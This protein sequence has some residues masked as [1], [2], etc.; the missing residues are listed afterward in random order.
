[1]GLFR[2][3]NKEVSNDREAYENDDSNVK[4]DMAFKGQQEVSGQATITDII[5][6]SFWSADANNTDIFVS[7]ETVAHRTYG[8]TMYIVPTGYPRAVDKN[9][10]QSAQA[11]GNTD[12]TVDIQ[13][14]KPRE[15]AKFLKAQ[16]TIVSSNSD[17]QQEKGQTFALKENQNK[18]QDIDTL[19][20]QNQFDENRLFDVNVSFVT[21]GNSMRELDLN[22]GQLEDDMADKGASV[23][24]YF[25]RVKTGYAQAIPIGYDTTQI[26][27]TF[28]NITSKGLG[29]F[30]LMSSGSGKF[31][32]GI[33]FAENLATAS[34][35]TEYLNVFGSSAHRPLNY[36]MGIIGES[37]GGK[38]FD[39]QI[40]I[41]RETAIL[42][43]RSRILDPEGEY[44]PMTKALGQLNLMVSADGGFVFNPI[45]IS[46][47]ELPLEEITEYREDGSLLTDDEIE[48]LY[49]LP[50]SNR[51]IVTKANGQ[52]FVQYVQLSEVTEKLKGF[53]NVNLTANEGEVGL[54]AQESARLDAV[55]QQIYHERGVT[56]DPDSLLTDQ[57]GVYQGMHYKRIPK[58]QPTLSDVYTKLLDNYSTRDANNEIVIDKEIRRVT[59][60]LKQNLRTGSVKIFDGQT[61]FGKI[62]ANSLNDFRLVNF[63]LKQLGDGPLK[64]VVY[65]VL[66]TYLWDE[67]MT[68][69]T[70][71]LE[72]KTI[73][74]DEILQNV[75][76]AAIM[77]FYEKIARRARKRNGSLVWMTQD[78][79]RFEGHPE[80]EALI[81]NTEHFLFLKIKPEHRL[82]MKVTFDLNDGVLQVLIS[83]P[84]PG[85]GILFVEGIP[86]WVRVNANEFEKDFAESNAENKLRARARRRLAAVEV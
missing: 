7:R 76:D 56:S 44:T 46:V 78:I 81:S 66:T 27:D 57:S 82:L 53:V 22:A 77:G 83:N 11:T 38:T 64:K 31:N 15:A 1:M 33:P 9:F 18:I 43:I 32:G 26:D 19:S 41:A 8:M 37:G 2:N 58:E 85:E 86:M 40:K 25:K 61:K 51:K 12:I 39:T 68:N 30:N 79:K 3:K 73:Y 67:W 69:P 84:Q 4:V 80:T 62:Q 50:E 75:D 5:A 60:V 24:P 49:K 36:N 16:R 52:K 55:M 13:P 59:D 17:Y 20:Q 21:Y 14:M 47:S 42:G 10:F 74:A 48:A 6:P 72:R 71:A 35:N 70:L 34:H 63:N 29:K 23:A 28:R 54:K 45:T 65:Y